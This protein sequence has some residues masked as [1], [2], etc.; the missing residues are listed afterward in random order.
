MK[1]EF[2]NLL[3]MLESLNADLLKLWNWIRGKK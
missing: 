2:N 1:N 3:Q